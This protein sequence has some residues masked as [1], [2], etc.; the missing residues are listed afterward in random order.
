MKKKI[1]VEDKKRLYIEDIFEDTSPDEAINKLI[2][3]CDKF[4]EKQDC[5]FTI[6]YGYE[7]CIEIYLTYKR[8]E[9]DD[10]YKKRLKKEQKAKDKKALE[11]KR[12]E[13]SERR[14]YEGLKKKF[15]GNN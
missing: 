1:F 5:K 14:Q 7:G 11:K 3:F 10:E 13:E 12:R 8:V 2:Q 15:G 9:T 6:D 4:K